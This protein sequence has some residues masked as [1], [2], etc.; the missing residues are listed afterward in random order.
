MRISRFPSLFFP[1]LFFLVFLVFPF[2][3]YSQS[4]ISEL[5]KQLEQAEDAK[6]HNK[7]AYYC[8]Q[9]AKSYQD[10]GKPD[11]MATYLEKCVSNGRKG[12]DATLLYLAYER[13]GEYERSVGNESRA[14]DNFQHALKVG[15]QLNK[16]DYIEES[17]INTAKAYAGLG[18]HKR[19]IEPLEE[20]LSIAVRQGDQAQQQRC[21]ALLA[22]YHGKLGNAA[23][24][25]EYKNLYASIEK[26]ARVQAQQQQNEQKLDELAQ[27]IEKAGKE[28]KTAYTQIKR[29]SRELR[30]VEDSLLAT[31]YTLE[32]QEQSLRELELINS[33]RQLQIDLLNKGKELSDM[34]IKE[35]NARIKNKALVIN[36]LIICTVLFGALVALAIIAYRRTAKA[37]QKIQQQNK[38]IKS[39]INYA[40]RIQEAMLPRKDQLDKLLPNSFVLFKPRDSVSG[41]FYWVSEIKSWYEPDVVF[42]AVDCTGH[43]IPGAL[44]SMIGMNSLNAIISRGIAESNQVL[45]ALNVE[46]R[47]ALQ[48]EKT[49]NNDGMDVALC[50][51]RREKSILEFSGA[52]NPLVYIQNNE[53]HQIKG[54]IHSIG[55]SK[56]KTNLTF[57]KHLVSIDQPTMI[58]LFSDGY[59]DQ[60]GGKENMKFMSKRFS[61]LLMDIHQ[62]PLDMQ[63]K[64]L[65]DTIEAW[66]GEGDQTDDILVM[67]I[68]L[69]PSAAIL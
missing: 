37:T 41:D 2:C 12:D 60:F 61:K 19:S 49:G 63:M 17:L 1:F 18:R 64:I 57:K 40:Q 5:E 20:A 44:M 8:Y 25:T 21:Y 53:L 65:N 55:G 62:K 29:Q 14:L 33:E 45:E 39:S 66:K 28:N 50:I 35:Q 67:G 13:L 32:A 47:T 42:A 6:D 26:T 48:Q 43:G 24:V 9:I 69:E 68:R 51:Y 38:A 11:K 7:A 59:R 22:E 34:T 36:S 10:S 27:K 54:D 3:A 56:R 52:K 31:R 30:K 4:A 58:Y 16:P 15:R 46:I 23:K